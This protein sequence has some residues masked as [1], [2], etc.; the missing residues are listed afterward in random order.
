MLEI[1]IL[2]APEVTWNGQ[3]VSITRRVPRSMLY[4]LATFSHVTARA[5]MM[6][7][8]WPD[9]D[10]HSAREAFR[11][12]LSKLRASL[13]EPDL[14]VAD[15]LSVGLDRTRVKV[16]YLEF[17]DI[18]QSIGRHPWMIQ[19]D[20]PLPDELL[21]Q[22]KQAAGLW[23]SAHMLEGAQLPPS[24]NLDDWLTLTAQT[25]YHRRDRIYH[26]LAYH[27][28]AVNDYDM[29]VYWLD[30]SLEVDQIN[31]ELHVLKLEILAR[32]GQR[33][34]ALRYG[35]YVKDLFQR[36]Y[37]EQPGG[38]FTTAL[39]RIKEQISQENHT[40]EQAEKKIATTGPR[41]IGREGLLVEM[42]QA[43]Q[44]GQ[45][46]Y[47]EGEIGS[48]KTRLVNEFYR[49]FQTP[50][51]LLV[52]PCHAATSG[53][54][55][56]P[57]I[58]MIR[59][60]I[61]ADELAAMPVSD[62]DWLAE[63]DPSFRVTGGKG[64][65]WQPDLEMDNLPHI[66]EAIYHLCRH[67][68]G[69]QKLLLLL[70]N[71][72]ASDEATIQTLRIMIQHR[73][74]DGPAALIVTA[75]RG[76]RNQG[77]LRFLDE[78]ARMKK[79][80][81]I[82]IPPMSAAEIGQ[83]VEA[84]LPAGIEE[85]WKNHI[86]QQLNG[87]P[88]MIIES[89]RTIDQGMAADKNEEGL[90]IIPV[91]IQSIL[92]ERYLNLSPTLQS[93]VAIVA[94]AGP[95]THYE[96]LEYASQLSPDEVADGLDELEK[97]GYLVSKPTHTG[98]SLTYSFTQQVFHNVVLLEISATRKRLLHR[99]M[100]AALDIVHHTDLDP[101]ASILAEHQEL[102]GEP[103]KSFANWYRSAMYARRL[104]APGD[105]IT[106]FRRAN[107]IIDTVEV[108][109][110]DQQLVEFYRNWAEVAY[111][112]HQPVA[113]SMIHNQ[114]M[115]LGGKRTSALLLGSGLEVQSLGLF[116]RNQFPEGLVVIDQALRYFQDSTSTAEWLRCCARKAKFLYMLNR[117]QEACET[118]E[119][120]LSS[121][122]DTAD[123]KVLQAKALLHYD[124]ATV[125]TLMGF[126]YKGVQE[127]EKSL[128]H[129]VQAQ[130]VEGQAKVYGILVMA[131]G[132]CG[133]TVRAESE[134]EIG[135]QLADRIQY[136]RMQAYIHV[137]VAMVKVCRG[138]MDE[139]WQ[140]A[141]TSLQI[142]EKFG[143][144][145]IL[146]LSLR[147]MGDIFRYLYNPQTA[148]E[149]YRKAYEASGETF[150]RY[151]SL[152]RLGFTLCQLGD[153]STGLEMIRTAQEATD[154]FEMG[155]VSISCRMYLWM[156]QN[157]MPA[158]ESIRAELEQVTTDSGE[159]GLL[160]QWGVGNG[161]LA[162]L[163]YFYNRPDDARSKIKEMIERGS[164]FE[165]LWAGLL[166]AILHDDK[167]SWNDL[168]FEE[169][170]QLVR[171]YIDQMDLNC[172]HPLLRES[173]EKFV[174]NIDKLTVI[175]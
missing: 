36:E 122:Q 166:F 35:Q 152:S 78:L 103:E 173:F 155:S 7:T 52:A 2:G 86:Y 62:Q 109:L 26:R 153:E 87:N 150:A 31:E 69:R 47:I 14:I 71:A 20:V 121:I 41:F 73:F 154:R 40:R 169:W 171:A 164:E 4:Y 17:Q 3:P 42:Q 8:F 76:V 132:F 113:L 27:Y 89:L 38:L 138:K 118:L 107:T 94:I 142:A 105:A 46:I 175:T 54:P 68:S 134:G 25:I 70:D 16:D 23:H 133:T 80:K 10:E 91:S 55:F 146:A 160:A 22:L 127:A 144:P 136:V 48:G 45:V 149:Y 5:T 44:R 77:V 151:D 112:S 39:Q 156:V 24:P 135:L 6:S 114:L 60:S 174:D 72:Q 11:D 117:L 12:N 84:V 58:E 75:E 100:A 116:S 59:T 104:G 139:G 49:K 126:P 51:R 148:V 83:L 131:N 61:N 137:Y 124:Y 167:N 81:R 172:R 1:R 66:H 92:R 163:D 130:D 50:P 157:Q 88:L 165:G 170:R 90:P 125:L 123:E 111:T 13:P 28:I 93:L 110:N 106:A 145:D 129:Y 56:R 57:F 34:E 43:Y 162:R 9:N 97:M 29:A 95:A 15:T 21:A 74:M 158:L 119:S 159:R 101:H 140:H 64:Q 79:L 37:N 141:N 128:A 168:F 143:Y 147:T 108:H 30:R 33:S 67:V 65:S 53:V 99:R 85:S 115:E 96:V 18:L 161:L 120:A 82:T 32:S 98:K 63:M 19:D 102:A